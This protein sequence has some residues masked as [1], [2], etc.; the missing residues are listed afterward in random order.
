MFAI[1]DITGSHHIH[2]LN[3]KQEKQSTHTHWQP[4]ATQSKVWHT[5]IQI[6][7][8]TNLWHLCGLLKSTM[9]NSSRLYASH[10]PLCSRG[11]DVSDASRLSALLW[12][13][14]CW[15]RTTTICAARFSD[16]RLLWFVCLSWSRWGQSWWIKYTRQSWTILGNNKSK[17]AARGFSALWEHQLKVEPR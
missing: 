9:L 5:R 7:T 13:S 2:I 14:D 16:F 15:R 8:H 1:S 12:S 4:K 10:N 11:C 6:H 17:D 3:V